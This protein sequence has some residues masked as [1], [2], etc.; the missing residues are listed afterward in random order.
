MDNDKKAKSRRYTIIKILT[1][2]TI[3][4]ILYPSIMI[5]YLGE[6]FSPFIAY[7]LTTSGALIACIGAWIGIVSAKKK[8]E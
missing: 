4:S 5:P 6:T 3:L 7:Y 8:S 2:L 1:T